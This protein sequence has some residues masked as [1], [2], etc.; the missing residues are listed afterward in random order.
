MLGWWVQSKVVGCSQGG[1]VQS[2]LCALHYGCRHFGWLQARLKWLFQAP[3]QAAAP[4]PAPRPHP[5]LPT[6]LP[7][8]PPIKQDAFLE[9]HGVKLGFMS[10]FVKAA[11]AA[12]QYVPAVNGV[13]DGNDIIYRCVEE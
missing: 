8:H 11:G 6:H 4:A 3:G 13:I 12:L 7:T 9:R 5:S 2:G 1:G 10:A